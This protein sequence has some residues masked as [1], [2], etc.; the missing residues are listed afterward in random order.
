MI[1]FLGNLNSLIWCDTTSAVRRTG[2]SPHECYQSFYVLP[3]TCSPRCDEFLNAFKLQPKAVFENLHTK[4]AK[5]SI[6]QLIKPLAGTYIILNLINGYIYIGSAITGRMPNR[7]YKHLYGFSGNK[8]V[9]AA[10]K[11]YGLQN[12]ASGGPEVCGSRYNLYNSK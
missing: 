4:G 10:V 8:L 7:F 9:V 3:L 5:T 12:F 1:A 6:S 11:K 2:F